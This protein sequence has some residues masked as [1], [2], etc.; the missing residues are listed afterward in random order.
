MPLPLHDT[1]KIQV[2]AV[3]A[4]K[5]GVGKSTVTV[6]VARAL[7][8]IGKR[9]GV[10]DADVYGPSVRRM[11]AEDRP[12]AQ[13]GPTLVPAMCG[14]IAYLS[15]AFFRK[16]NEAA[17]VR[18]P[19]A[20]SLMQH[21]LTQVD[22]GPLDYLL[23]DF[24]PG[25]GDVQ[26]TLCQKANLGGALMVTTPQEVA[27]MDVRKAMHLFTQMHV[28]VLGIVENMSY[29]LDPQGTTHYLFGQGGGERLARESGCPFLGQIPIAPSLSR[30]GDAGMSPFAESAVDAQI[31]AK[32]FFALAEQVQR[33]WERQRREAAECIPSFELNWK[34]MP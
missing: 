24:P 28:P 7:H 3:A 5:G 20:N 18:A 25:T 34:E 29:Y 27:V 26:M 12:P 4:G 1:P 2:L 21:F 13:K 6:N 9:V 15:M 8:A 17:A 10:L 31:A 22:W 11:L 14:G 32:A 33:E 23:I 16:E 30:C 19:I